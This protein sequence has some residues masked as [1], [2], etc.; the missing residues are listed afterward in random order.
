MNIFIY[1]IVFS[2]FFNCTQMIEDVSCRDTTQSSIS[3]SEGEGDGDI[4]G[5]AGR[6][7]ELK[8]LLHGK[9][10]MIESLSAEIEH[11]R[12]EA[13]S[14]NS[15]QSH[16]SISQDREILVVYKNKVNIYLFCDVEL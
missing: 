10:A 15:S 1:F 14:P 7:A 12:T 16:N 8:E 6:V 2:I 4:E 5:M 13:C 9:E 3:V 11:M